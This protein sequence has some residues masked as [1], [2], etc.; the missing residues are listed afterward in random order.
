MA[1]MEIEILGSGT[2]T[3]V[4]Q[5]GCTC[6]VCRSRDPRDKR[7]RSSIVVRYKGKNIIIDCGPDF[8]TQMLRASDIKLDAL[9][10]T[11][12]HY[13]H[14]GGMDDLRAYCKGGAFPVY[15]RQD[16]I[17]SLK[18]HMP[19]CFAGHHYPGAPRLD[20]HTVGEEPFD[21]CGIEVMPITVLHGRLPIVG[22]RIGDM[23]YV[24]DAK[25]IPAESMERLRGLRL[26]V[27]NSLRIEPHFSHMSLS[28]SLQ[29]VRE[30][31]PQEVYFTH[32]SHDMGLHEEVS[33][34][35]PDNV[36]LAYDGLIVKVGSAQNSAQ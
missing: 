21:V 1:E 33:R 17:D 8:R 20:I 34:H 19:Y 9:L 7:L 14:V 22:Y 18:R 28:E 3:G 13:D 35:L 26:L 29:V 24:T 2:S 32:I 30:L 25:T 23:A 5:I 11:H 27:V 16:V 6:R 36:H 12:I 31:A 15:A 4:P 10:V